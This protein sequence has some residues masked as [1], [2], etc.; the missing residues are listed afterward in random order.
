MP[1]FECSVP[2]KAGEIWRRWN[3]FSV[4]LK[5][6]GEGL[7][8]VSVIAPDELT[9]AET[10]VARRDSQTGWGERIPVIEVYVRLTAPVAGSSHVKVTIEADVT[11]VLAPCSDAADA[12][13]AGSSG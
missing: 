12:C 7:R 13:E 6:I 1:Q 4:E 11:G 3:L 2:F 8:I 5:P 10:A 9:V